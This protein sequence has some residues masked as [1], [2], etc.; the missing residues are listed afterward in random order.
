MLFAKG[1]LFSLKDQADLGYEVLGID[2][3]VNPKEARKVVQNKNVTLQGNLD[4]CALYAPKEKITE[5][6]ER[7]IENFG[8]EKYI[9][10]LGH[11]IYPDADVDAV[12]TFIDAV[13]DF[14]IPKI[15]S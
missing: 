6:T 4:P 13:H 12:Q 10:N 2:W 9:V 8:W 7:M 14:K 5:L 15:N 11:G 3:T 1:A